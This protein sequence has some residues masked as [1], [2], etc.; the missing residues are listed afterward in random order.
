MGLDGVFHV[1]R[2]TAGNL[3]VV[4]P[5]FMRQEVGEWFRRLSERTNGHARVRMDPPARPI[6]KGFRGQLPR[7]W[8]H[9]G[10]IAEQI[11]TD[12]R[13]YT[14]EDVDGALRRMAVREGL[15]T[16][17]NA[18]DDA[19]EAIHSSE[20]TVED[21]NIVEMVKQRFCDQHGLYLTEY[22]E[23]PDGTLEPYK[24]VAGRTRDEMRR[25]WG[26]RTNA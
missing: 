21:A 23:N 6:K 8:G 10:D 15:R 3:V 4:I 1:E 18:I 14:K 20:W 5:G 25:Y 12:D 22:H 11:S 19:V 26:E 9:C 13:R 24:S 17:Y 7:H 16:V 2:Q